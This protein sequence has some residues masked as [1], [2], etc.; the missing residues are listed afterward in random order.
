MGC[1][2]ALRPKLR[3]EAVFGLLA[4]FTSAVE[5]SGQSVNQRRCP[6]PKLYGKPLMTYPDISPTFAQRPALSAPHVL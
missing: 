5:Q 6:L 4:R 3:L 1:S 2:T